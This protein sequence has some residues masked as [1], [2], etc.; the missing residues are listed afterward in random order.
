MPAVFLVLVSDTISLI[1]YR[2]S[3]RDAISKTNHRVGIPATRR[4]ARLE[5]ITGIVPVTV[6]SPTQLARSDWHGKL[7]LSYAKFR[8]PTRSRSEIIVPV[9]NAISKRNHRVRRYPMWP[10]ARQKIV[11]VSDAVG[12]PSSPLHSSQRARGTSESLT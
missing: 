2:A 3:I 5:K 9:T 1:N 12:Y 4:L 11:L 6:S 10:L 8:Y 7:L